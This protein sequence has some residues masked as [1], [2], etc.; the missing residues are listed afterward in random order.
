M[1]GDMHV[2]APAHCSVPDVLATLAQR[3]YMFMAHA[4][5]TATPFTACCARGMRREPACTELRSILAN[6]LA[7]VSGKEPGADPCDTSNHNRPRAK[8]DYSIQASW[9]SQHSL[10]ATLA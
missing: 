5:F 10:T 6:F 9:T 2:S 1:L 4:T 7:I 3:L 8:Q